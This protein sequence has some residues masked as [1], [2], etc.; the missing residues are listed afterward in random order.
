MTLEVLGYMD[1]DTKMND[2]RVYPAHAFNPQTIQYDIWVGVGTEEVIE[3]CGFKADRA[4]VLHCP[5]EQLVDG[6]AYRH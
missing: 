6:W 5:K 4:N 1:G 3:K 2:T